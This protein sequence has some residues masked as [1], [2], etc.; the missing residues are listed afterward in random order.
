M[1]DAGDPTDIFR[2]GV[3]DDVEIFGREVEVLTDEDS[4]RSEEDEEGDDDKGMGVNI[5]E[6]REFI[7]SLVYQNKR[8]Y[9]KKKKQE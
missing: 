2:F 1:T 8:K 6:L 7:R 3:A 9:E 4:L 5:D